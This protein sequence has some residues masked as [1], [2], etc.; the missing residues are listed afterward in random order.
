MAH[1][2][3]CI[4]RI[5]TSAKANERNRAY[6]SMM[7]TS[8]KRIQESEN[9]ETAVERLISVSS[10]IDKMVLKGVL[11]RNNANNKKSRLTRWVNKTHAV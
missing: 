3:S 8:I 1:H 4:K 9:R 10:L 7:K 6:R 2:K 5:K 11:H